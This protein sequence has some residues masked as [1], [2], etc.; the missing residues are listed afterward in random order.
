MTARP[1]CCSRCCFTSR[2]TAVSRLLEPV[3]SRRHWARMTVVS[4][5]SPQG[6]GEGGPS[7]NDAQSADGSR[8]AAEGQ[9]VRLKHNCSMR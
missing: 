2:L 9:T 8:H 4:R 6:R 5:G 7:L 3:Q 1:C